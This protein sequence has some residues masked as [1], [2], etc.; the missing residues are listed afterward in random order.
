VKVE[1]LPDPGDARHRC[2]PTITNRL[3]GCGGVM[4][5]VGDRSDSRP[6]GSSGA[7]G[8]SVL[9]QCNKCGRWDHERFPAIKE[10]KRERKQ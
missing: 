7:T 1:W 2:G 3:K 10:V 8:V 9:L 4:C 5:V 6:A